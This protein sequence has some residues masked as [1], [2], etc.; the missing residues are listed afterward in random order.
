MTHGPLTIAP[1]ALIL[2]Y[3]GV[4]VTTSKRPTGP[5]ELAAALDATLRRAGV[6]VPVEVLERS[7]RSGVAALRDYNNMSSRRREPRELTHHEIVTDFLASDLPDR[8]RL[9][10]GADAARV[11]EAKVRLLSEHTLRP[12]VR[13]LLLAARSRGIRT[14]VASNAQSGA[15]HRTFIEEHDLTELIDIQLYSDEFGVRK[16][17]PDMLRTVADALAIPIEECWY[18]GDTRDRDLLAGRRAG[19][20]AV[21]LIRHRHT[22]APPYGVD[23]EPDA[24]FDEVT[25]LLAALADA[26]PAPA[27]APAG[28]AA[29]KA[30]AAT[31]RGCPK[32]LLLDNGG[33]LSLSEKSPDGVRDFVAY[34][35][36]RLH[37][38]GHDLD[39]ARL[40]ADL[41]SGRR[42]YGRWKAEHDG[43]D[44]VPEITP[45]EFWATMVAADWPAGA[46]AAVAADARDLMYRYV[47]ARAV[48]RLRPGILDVLLYAH[49][50]G[51]RVGIVSN[52][53]CGRVPRATHVAWKL[54]PYLGVS[55][56]S[57]EFGFRKPDPSIVLACASALGVDPLDCWFV[58]DKR[59]RDVAAARRAGIGTSVLIE[60]RQTGGS[61]GPEPSIAVPDAAGLLKVL[62]AAT[63]G[64]Q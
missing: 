8:A 56:F 2:D 42:R 19:V 62:V 27:K 13:E 43:G 53:M 47:A 52:T 12:G 1:R 6:E 59:G 29:G 39:E 7:V 45:A 4:V 35:A 51:I 54:E 57:D 55:F 40:R 18:V 61:A 31:G 32:A 17:H 36:G 64:G 22:D 9:V 24:I 3:G 23:G 16:P 33:V 5:A 44:R 38:A 49:E 26:R 15:A 21:V 37:R 10:L 25:G 60:S 58:G 50:A 46:R 41:E 63:R 14:G 30:P 20:G 28:T 11:C 48:R 34:L